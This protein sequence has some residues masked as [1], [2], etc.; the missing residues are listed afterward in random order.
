M[1]ESDQ[2][3]RLDEHMRWLGHVAAM[4]A[5]LD[6]SVNMAIWELANVE[7]WIGACL[8][9]QLFSPSSRF[10]VLISLIQVRGGSPDIITKVNKFAERAGGLA[11]RRN[12]YVHDPWTIEEEGGGVH[13]IHVTMEGTFKFGFTPTS[14]EELKRLHDDIQDSIL[15]FDQLREEV[16]RSLPP[17]P[18]T[19]FSRSRGI[20]S[21]LTDRNTAPTEP[22]PPPQS[23][24]G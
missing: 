14:I 1:S 13:R 15:R 16:F 17:W 7:R 24:K 9:T 23:S 11:R 12:A 4:S 18:R 22:Q 19:Q 5:S 3:P 10:R 6:F 2:D 20:R 21:Y 8:T